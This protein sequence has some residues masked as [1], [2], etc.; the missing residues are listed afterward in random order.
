MGVG[1]AALQIRPRHPDAARQRPLKHRA[2][3][4]TCWRALWTSRVVVLVC[5]VF[6]VLQFGPAHSST[7]YDPARLTA[8]FSYLGNLLVSPL[9]RWDSVWY[10]AIAG[11]GY[12]HAA[13][14]TA[15]YPI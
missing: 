7:S 3:L 10:L 6:A 12:D 9:A 4:Q 2:E 8:P 13:Q 15:F 14:R 5:G 11:G 1:P